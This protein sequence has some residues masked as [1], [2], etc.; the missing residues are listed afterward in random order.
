KGL[1]ESVF[2]VASIL[3]ALAVDEWAQDQEYAELADQSLSIFE[4]EIRDNRARLDDV[5][6]YHMGI[7]DLLGQMRELPGPPR[8]ISSF[9][10]G[11]SPPV[12]LNTAWET[13]LAT[14]ALTHMEFEVVSALSLTYSIQESFE[15]RSR[16]SRPRIVSTEGLSPAAIRAQVEEAYDYVATLS[17]DESELMTVYDQAL[18]VIAAHRAPEHV[19]P[20]TPDATDAS[21]SDRP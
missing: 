19:D 20:V 11:M 14:G 4:R 16:A 8:E 5:A 9:M 13:A 7:R 2:V 1:V 21:G 6:P 10:E 12:L 17:Q 3:M 18:E 15:D